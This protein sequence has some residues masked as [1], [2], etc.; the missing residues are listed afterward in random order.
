MKECLASAGQMYIIGGEYEDCTSDEASLVY[1]T[2][3]RFNPAQDTIESIA[4]LSIARKEHC[5]CVFMG[6]I[7]VL[8][9]IKIYATYNL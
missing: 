7:F 5:A 2:C 1:N 8:G 9:K 3:E 4:P 6:S